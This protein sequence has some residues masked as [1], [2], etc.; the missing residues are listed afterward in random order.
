MVRNPGPNFQYSTGFEG[1]LSYDID[2][3][4]VVSLRGFTSKRFGVIKLMADCLKNIS[5]C[6]VEVLYVPSFLHISISS[7]L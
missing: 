2:S 3:C 7:C 6:Y 4:R 5:D 1:S